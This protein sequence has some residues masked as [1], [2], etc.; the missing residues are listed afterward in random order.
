MVIVID[1]GTGSCK[2][3]LAGN[4][5][6]SHV[7]PTIVGRPHEGVAALMKREAYVGDEAQSKRGLL[8]IKNPIDGG[9]IINWDDMEMVWHHSFF[10]MLS[11]EPQEHAI[12]LSEPPH[13]PRANKEKMRQIMFET[14]NTPSLLI[15]STAMLSFYTSGRSTALI[16]ACGEGLTSVV[17]I[18]EGN[19]LHHAALHSNLA[20]SCVTK[21]LRKLLSDRGHQFE[22]SAEMEVV[23][24]IK[25]KTAFVPLDYGEEFDRLN[26]RPDLN[27]SHQLPDGS[28]IELGA[29]RI[30][31]VEALFRPSLIGLEDQSGIHELAYKS[32]M[33]CSHDERRLLWGD[34]I[35]SGGS[36][37]PRGF[38]DRM[39]RELF[40]LAPCSTHVRVVAPPERYISSWIGGSIIGSL[41]GSAEGFTSK[42]EYEESGPGIV[43]PKH[44]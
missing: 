35:L 33:K 22:S 24:D 32:L 2:T 40:C 36:T 29:E 10:N 23:R 44:F 1:T 6:P 7:I 5:A 30:T 19:V 42:Q 39:E 16:V 34:V 3:G 25:E 38:Q 37:M 21:S 27:V 26:S 31:C 15:E 43:Y 4:D 17:P 8:T 41:C 14:F 13:N 20:G 11:L 18:V 28:S 9:V 12:I